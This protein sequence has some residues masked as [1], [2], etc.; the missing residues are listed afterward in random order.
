MTFNPGA[1][2]T[3]DEIEATEN[4][5]ATPKFTPELVDYAKKHLVYHMRASK[6]YTEEQITKAEEIIKSLDQ[7]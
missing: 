2:V 5:T 7:K 1:S 6:A 3:M 4:T